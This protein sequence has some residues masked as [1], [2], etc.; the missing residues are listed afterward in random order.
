MVSSEFDRDFSLCL[1]F[2]VHII[3]FGWRDHRCCLAVL[4]RHWPWFMHQY[5]NDASAARAGQRPLL[6]RR[7]LSTNIPHH[8]ESPLKNVCPLSTQPEANPLTARVGN[9]LSRYHLHPESKMNHADLIDRLPSRSKEFSIFFGRINQNKPVSNEPMHANSNV[10]HP[11]LG[12][13]LSG[14]MRSVCCNQFASRFTR[15]RPLLSLTENTFS[16]PNAS[17][18]YRHSRSKMRWLLQ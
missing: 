14:R 18:L 2:L 7:Y 9:L 16:S 8:S 11:M 4:R 10:H 3:Q 12:R 1:A 15:Q 5:N 17:Q 13:V 6:S